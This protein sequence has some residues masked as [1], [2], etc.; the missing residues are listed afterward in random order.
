METWIFPLTVLPGIGLLI[1]STTH[2]AVALTGEIDHM[3]SDHS[4]ARD[5]L[6]RK[7]R[8][9]GLINR[10]LVFLYIC[11]GLL[12]AAGFIGALITWRP[13]DLQNVVYLITGLGILM[14]LVANGMLIVYSFRAYAI[15]RSQ[16][17]RRLQQ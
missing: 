10:A 2:W 6:A 4:C 14:L 15:K 1:M 5:I 9:L 11:A 16:F 3:L 8:Q 13:S 7:V 17:E 12:A